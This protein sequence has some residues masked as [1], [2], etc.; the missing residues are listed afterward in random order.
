MP[1]FLMICSF[2]FAIICTHSDLLRPTF[3]LAKRNARSASVSV[4]P[5]CGVY[6]ELFKIRVY[7]IVFSSNITKSVCEDHLC[8]EG[9]CL[10]LLC[11]SLFQLEALCNGPTK[12]ICLLKYFNSA[13]SFLKSSGYFFS[14][15]LGWQ[16]SSMKTSGVLSLRPS[17]SSR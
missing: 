5:S 11:I 6:D 17:M 9:Q 10:L 1:L 13:A 14:E 2:S 16:S 8:Q 3:S 7:L 4:S 15:K 12:T